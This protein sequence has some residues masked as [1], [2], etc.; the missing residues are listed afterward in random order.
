M[1]F[2][3]RAGLLTLH[4]SQFKNLAGAHNMDA[5]LRET[6]REALSRIVALRDSL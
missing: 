1:S 4:A 6:A 5:E 2:I 3:Q